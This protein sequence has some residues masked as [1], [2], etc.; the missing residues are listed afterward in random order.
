MDLFIFNL[1]YLLRNR[2]YSL[3]NEIFCSNTPSF[4]FFI[5]F[6]SIK[7]NNKQIMARNFEKLPSYLI[8][9]HEYDKKVEYPVEM[10][11]IPMEIDGL[12]N[13]YATDR[14]SLGCLRNFRRRVQSLDCLTKIGT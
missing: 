9:Y 8:Q 7:I 11:Q 2:K 5:I 3:G 6:Y 10:H 14:F 12:F 13:P 1:F 4:L